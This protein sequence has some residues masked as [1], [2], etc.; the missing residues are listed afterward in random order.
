MGLVA[1]AA[2]SA[3]ALKNISQNAKYGNAFPRTFWKCLQIGLEVVDI[4]G[5]WLEGLPV[6]PIG[7]DMKRAGS[8]RTG[9]P[10]LSYSL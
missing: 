4:E 5:V 6:P 2:V 8:S 9:R 1:R 7:V 3:N 10:N